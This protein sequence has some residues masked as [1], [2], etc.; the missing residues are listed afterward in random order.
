MPD[1]TKLRLAIQ[2][3]KKLYDKLESA[4]GTIL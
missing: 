2:E 3:M 1:T 4:G